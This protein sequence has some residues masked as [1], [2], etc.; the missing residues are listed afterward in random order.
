V[1]H[2]DYRVRTRRVEEVDSSGPGEEADV[3]PDGAEATAAAND[4]VMHRKV[5]R[6]LHVTILNVLQ[7][8]HMRKNNGL[9][10]LICYKHTI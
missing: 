6:P 8:N 3:V 9:T 5:I 7:E 4:I 10:I 2:R 1:K